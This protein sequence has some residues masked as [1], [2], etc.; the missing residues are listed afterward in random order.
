MNLFRRRIPKMHNIRYLLCLISTISWVKADDAAN[1]DCVLPE[2]FAKPLHT[3]YE[4]KKLSCAA[5]TLIHAVPKIGEKAVLETPKEDQKNGNIVGRKA[6]EILAEE[7]GSG[8]PEVPSKDLTVKST[9]GEHSIPIRR[10]E[11]A[12]PE[13]T[14]LFVHGGGWSR[15][16]LKTH[17][18]LCR[19]L[20]KETGSTV[21]AVDYRLAPENPYP[22]GLQDVEDV[23]EWLMN[24]S[25]LSH[26]VIIAGDSGGGNLST[27]FILKR[28]QSKKE[29]PKGAILIYPALD[30]RV[31]QETDN[32]YTNGYLLTRDGI[33]QY[34]HNYLGDDYKVKSQDPLVSPLLASDDDLKQ[35]PPVILVSAQCDP[36]AKEGKSFVKRL[37]D[38]DVD[39]SYEVI[40]STIHIFAQFFDLFPEATDAMDFIKD[41]FKDKFV[42][43]VKAEDDENN[44]EEEADNESDDESDEESDDDQQ[45]DDNEGED[46]GEDDSENSEA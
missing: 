17:D 37:E 29:G 27:A 12:N 8:G 14:I 18:Q 36:L 25:D 19:K 24:Q 43:Q 31:P 16:N 38:L 26:D 33:N 4:N 6:Y 15:G 2:K 10:Y 20:A 1:N 3:F 21:V 40:P 7:F 11:G 34:V 39:V 28:I 30:L 44:V 41:E 32:S 22:A 13:K 35:F 42:G 45:E 5:N 46:E 23:Y 9:H